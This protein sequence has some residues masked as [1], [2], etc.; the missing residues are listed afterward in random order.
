VILQYNTCIRVKDVASY[1]LA[2]T[3]NQTQVQ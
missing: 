3:A 1:E 2:F